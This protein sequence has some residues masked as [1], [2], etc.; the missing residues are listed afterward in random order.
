MLAEYAPVHRLPDPQPLEALAPVEARPARDA[1][2]ERPGR[3]RDCL[4]REVY[5]DCHGRL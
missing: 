1:A 2:E 3:E 4:L 5:R